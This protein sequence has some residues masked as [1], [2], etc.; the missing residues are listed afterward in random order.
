MHGR[1]TGGGSLELVSIQGF[2]LQ[3]FDGFCPVDGGLLEML[4]IPS[5]PDGCEKQQHGGNK[6][7]FHD[8]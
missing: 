1:E 5:G 2:H 6:D 7:A 3:T 4:P 8:Q